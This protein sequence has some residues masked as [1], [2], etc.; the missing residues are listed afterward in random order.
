MSSTEFVKV[1]ALSD[2]PEEGVLGVEIDDTPVALVRSEGEVFAV[3]D[4]CSHAEV[5]L[6][7]GEV[8]DG[9]IECWLHGSC[10]DLRSGAPINPPATTPVPTYVVKID[11]DD[12]LVS[13]NEQ[14]S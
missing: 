10:F 9:T 2:I 7:E 5:N 11:G 4:I 3:S 1:C 14:N 8:E 6:S 12:V 13:L